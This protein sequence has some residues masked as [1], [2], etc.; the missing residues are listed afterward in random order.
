MA[1][2]DQIVAGLKPGYATYL[3]YVLNNHQSIFDTITGETDYSFTVTAVPKNF[4]HGISTIESNSLIG[5]YTK[6]EVSNLIY[7]IDTRSVRTTKNIVNPFLSITSNKL[8]DFRGLTDIGVYDGIPLSLSK[9]ILFAKADTLYGTDDVA[10]FDG[11]IDTYGLTGYNYNK[12][13]A[14]LSSHSDSTDF[15]SSEFPE[16]CIFNT[17]F[18]RFFGQLSGGKLK[19]GAGLTAFGVLEGSAAI[20]RLGF[21]SLKNCY[22]D[23]D[24]NTY[25]YAKYVSPVVADGDFS[26][27]FNIVCKFRAADPTSSDLIL[28]QNSATTLKII[29][30]KSAS[31]TF[32]LK[33]FVTYSDTTTD[34]LTSRS[35]TVNENSYHVI[36]VLLDNENDWIEFY[37]DGYLIDRIAYAIGKSPVSLLTGNLYLG[38]DGSAACQ[39]LISSCTIYDLGHTTDTIQDITY[40]NDNK[41]INKIHNSI[42][43]QY[44]IVP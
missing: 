44:Q 12:K 41:I 34:T 4:I 29:V 18:S 40:A 35:V 23:F 9:N 32:V 26:T 15:L 17:D 11:V 8:Q 2:I 10:G 43:R 5:L 22:I 3:Q 42:S 30:N 16:Y 28:L 20:A 24:F 37:L 19:L 38:G 39:I 14:P 31:D 13:Y 36:G 27:L 7:D 6:L 21:D 25:L 1:T 33:T